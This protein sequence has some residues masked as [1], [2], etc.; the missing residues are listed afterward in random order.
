MGG[1]F[2][3]WGEAHGVQAALRSGAAMPSWNAFGK[4]EIAAPSSPEVFRKLIVSE[5]ARW[6]PVMTSGRVRAE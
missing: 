5:I 3:K 1:S 4:V 6:K 2:E